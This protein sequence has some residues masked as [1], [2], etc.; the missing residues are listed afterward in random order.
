EHKP[1]PVKVTLVALK[2]I[3]SSGSAAGGSAA[4]P[5]AAAKVENDVKPADGGGTKTEVAEKSNLNAPAP[6]ATIS[7]AKGEAGKTAM[8]TG[9]AKIAAGQAAESTP[10]GTAASGAATTMVDGGPGQTAD[11]AAKTGPE[12]KTDAIPPPMPPAPTGAAK[13]A[14]DA[15]HD[16]SAAPDNAS[17]ADSNR[18]P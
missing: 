5:V 18:K 10:P 8:E 6:P 11:N 16:V 3:P 1:N 2:P 12:R 7:P 15:T 14:P 13:A 9:G 4:N 17:T